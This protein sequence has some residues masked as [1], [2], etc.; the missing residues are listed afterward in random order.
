MRPRFSPTFTPP[1][2]HIFTI[3]GVDI[4]IFETFIFT[5]TFLIKILRERRKNMLIHLFKSEIISNMKFYCRLFHLLVR[6][7]E[8]NTFTAHEVTSDYGIFHF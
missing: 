8:K 1:F 6:L 3:L 4:I 7:T 5:V 2:T